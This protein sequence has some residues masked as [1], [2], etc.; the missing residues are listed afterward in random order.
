[1]RWEV[2]AQLGPGA[3][4][5]GLA[6]WLETA[7]SPAVGEV[8][9]VDLVP[10]GPQRDVIIKLHDQ[11]V[12]V[13]C[14]RLLDDG[15]LVPGPDGFQCGGLVLHEQGWNAH[16]LRRVAATIA[17]LRVGVV[18]P[19]RVPGCSIQIGGL[20]SPKMTP[21][22]RPLNVVPVDDV[23]LQDKLTTAVDVSADSEYIRCGR[24]AG[25]GLDARRL[26]NGG[27]FGRWAGL[28]GAG[29]QVCVV[30]AGQPRRQVDVVGLVAH[31][32]VEIA[33]VPARPASSACRSVPASALTHAASGVPPAEPGWRQ[34]PIEDGESGG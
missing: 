33:Q 17:V 23:A 26:L 15:H 30:D 13:G 22:C 34:R 5:H 1:M 12:A 31:A 4:C 11:G 32:E 8:A 14:L 24:C 9:E 25:G 18:W 3:W 2:T 10:V 19:G 27:F 16:V 6:L 7:G 29:D 20:V 21:G 28:E